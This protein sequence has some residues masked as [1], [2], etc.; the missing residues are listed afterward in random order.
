MSETTITPTRK[1]N[2]EGL[3]GCSIRFCSYAHAAE[4]VWHVM[5]VYPNSPAER[6]GLRPDHGISVLTALGGQ[7]HYYVCR[8][9]HWN[10]G[11]AD[12]GQER[13]L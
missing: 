4:N 11:G 5:S 2:G 9:Y 13:S 10:T 3:L 8:L 1:W 7:T 12:K 6:A